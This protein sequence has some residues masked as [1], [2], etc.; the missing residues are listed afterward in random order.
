VNVTVL[1]NGTPWWRRRI[2]AGD[3]LARP[4]ETGLRLPTPRS[5]LTVQITGSAV[6]EKAAVEHVVACRPE[7][8]RR[9]LRLLVVGVRAGDDREKLRS[10]ALGAFRGRLKA[11][12]QGEFDTPVFEKGVLYGPLSGDDA[13]RSQIN[14]QLDL[15]RDGLTG[16]DEEAFEAATEVIVVY[17]RGDEHRSPSSRSLRL[18]GRGEEIG[19]DEIHRQFAGKRGCQVYLLDVARDPGPDDAPDFPKSLA[20]EPGEARPVRL[21]VS[22]LRAAGD[23]STADR[24]LGVLRGALPSPSTIE[25]LD[26]T[27]RDHY[28]GRRSD[29]DYEPL[30][31]PP[32]RGTI[33]V[34]PEVSRE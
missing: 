19:L 6:D 3:E 18:G 22:W 16:L 25:E 8:L 4:F 1:V 34:G 31:D 30:V 21:R 32:H 13:E 24:L 2:A 33:L 7:S 26:E 20:S 27:L 14:G 29:L 9:W 5:L 10:E 17:Y 11:A 23:P 28:R 15:I 12:Q